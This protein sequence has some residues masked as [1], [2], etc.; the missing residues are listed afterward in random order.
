MA[1]QV[2]DS[3]TGAS[4]AVRFWPAASATTPTDHPAAGTVRGTVL[5]F[6][7]LAEHGG[8]YEGLAAKLS[9]KGFDVYA[10]D[11]RGHGATT[12]RDAPPR[13]FAKDD[14]MAKVLADC[15]AVQVHA[16]ARRPGLPIMVLGHSMGGLIAV[17]YA[18]RFGSDLA[19]VAV[20]NANLRVG[21]AER[22][23]TI[24]LSVEKALKGS[25]VPSAIL[26]RAT[27]DAWAKSVTS[28]R[29]PFDWLSHDPAAVDAYI[30]DPLCGFSPTL[31]MMQDILALIFAGGSAAGLARLPH[32]LP[33]QLLGGTA[34]PATD[35]AGAMRWL[36]DRL[37]AAG[38]RDVTLTVV[39]GARH[40]THHEIEPFRSQ[41]FD[42][43]SAW[44]DRIVPGNALD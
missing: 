26:Q 29:T 32:R 27:F 31:S 23:A 6:H 41:A 20:W 19:G 28:R 16:A 4:L 43:L 8:R 24:A 37:R 10:H 38:L 18:E 39:E 12:A 13:R 40:E 15:R 2:L 22:V 36:A 44:L 3:S 17:N 35:N 11:H 25:D 14:G 21:A 30:A 42:A 34:D 5:V 7:G 9:A 33:V 1:Q